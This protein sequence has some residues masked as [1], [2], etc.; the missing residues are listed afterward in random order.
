MTKRKSTKSALISS[1]LA[2]FLCFTMLLGTTFAWFTDSVTSA[3]NIIQAGNLNVEM[4]WADGDE[5]PATLTW[6]KVDGSAIFNNDKWEPGYVE[7]KHIKIA[8]EGTLAFKWRLRI[9]PNGTVEELADVI[10]VYY[11]EG[12]TQ[13]TR[14][15][16]ETVTPIC[17]L[18]D[19][20]DDVDGAAHGALLPSTETETTNDYERIGEVTA[21]IAFK[22]R[23]DAGNEYQDKKIGTDFSL[24]LMATQYAYEEDSFD[25]Q[26][27]VNAEADYWDGTIDETWYDENA[28]EL[29]ITTAEELAAFAAAVNNANTFAGKTVKLGRDINLNNLEWTPIGEYDG[30]KVFRG[31]FNGDAHIISNLKITKTDN[32]SATLRLGLFSHIMNATVENVI[33]D[34]VNIVANSANARAAAFIM[35]AEGT[36]TIK[37]IT[38]KNAVVDVTSTSNSGYVA[39]VVGYANQL[40]DKMSNINVSGLSLNVSA[41]NYAFASAINGYLVQDDKAKE[42]E[43]KSVLDG[44]SVNGVVVSAKGVESYVGGAYG[45]C[46]KGSMDIKNG[47]ITNLKITSQA[48]NGNDA[49]IGGLVGLTYKVDH[50]VSENIVISDIDVDFT[51]TGTRVGGVTGYDQSVSDYKNVTVSGTIN[52]NITTGSGSEIGGF[53]GISYYYP[54]TYVDCSADVD[55]VTGGVAGGFVG[56]SCTN[57]WANQTDEYTSCVARGDV[58]ADCAGGFAGKAWLTNNT[59]MAMTNVECDGAV[60][61][62]IHVGGM[63]GYA[64]RSNGNVVIKDSTASQ[65]VVGT[66]SSTTVG[67]I[68]GAGDAKVTVE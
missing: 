33:L 40:G 65:T 64:G 45:Y 63:I 20:I 3:G 14:E 68:I 27:D 13:L 43:F 37:D 67:E 58:T 48:N 41:S 32:T 24:Q 23:E 53:V 51:G 30:S 11:V 4:Y 16:L 61:G 59:T 18:R 47:T 1:V 42:S 44:F 9:V 10:D 8:N 38:V 29:I 55:V 31:T 49:G 60:T 15:M 19:L 12:A 57:G 34:T 22:M 7:A 66:V 39:G 17:T 36:N 6:N 2:L 46:Q 54:K 56:T 26:Y 28:D 50:Q 21:T 5:D 25:N 35:T 52:E 62:K